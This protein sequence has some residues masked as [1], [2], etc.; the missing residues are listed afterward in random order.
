MRKNSKIAFGGILDYKMTDTSVSMIDVEATEGV[1]RNHVMVLVNNN[2]TTKNFSFVVD[3]A[4]HE[5]EATL[6][7]VDEDSLEL[8]LVDNAPTENYVFHLFLE[9]TVGSFRIREADKTIWM[10][11]WT[12]ADNEW[13]LLSSD[14]ECKPVYITDTAEKSIVPKAWT[15]HKPQREKDMAKVDVMFNGI[16]LL[17]EGNKQ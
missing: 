2:Y 5:T 15:K 6:Y 17:K 13:T 16:N 8:G 12:Y 11:N 4:V 14:R 10:M 7:P 9:R 3:G 1:G